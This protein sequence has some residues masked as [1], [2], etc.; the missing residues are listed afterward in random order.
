VQIGF[1][2][3]DVGDGYPGAM[4]ELEQLAGKFQVLPFIGQRVLDYEGKFGDAH[5]IM[6]D[7]QRICDRPVNVWPE[8]PQ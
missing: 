7:M 1:I 6:R 8:R 2:L 3:R 5:E 4:A